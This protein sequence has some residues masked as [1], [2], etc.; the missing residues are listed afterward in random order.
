MVEVDPVSFYPKSPLFVCFA[1]SCYYPFLRSLTHMS[2]SN[3]VSK[4]SHTPKCPKCHTIL[5]SVNRLENETI[6]PLETSVAAM[7]LQEAAERLMSRV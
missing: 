5:V 1:T 4:I 2:F 3:S 6:P 7:S